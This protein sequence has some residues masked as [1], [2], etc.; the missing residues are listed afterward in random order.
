MYTVKNFKTKKALREAISAGE[1]VRVYQ[2]NNIF[3]K[4]IPVSGTVT[5]EGP[6]Y[7]EAHRWYAQGVLEN[8]VLISVK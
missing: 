8:G 3:N 2:P 4:E 7:P 1:Q 5:L 6:H